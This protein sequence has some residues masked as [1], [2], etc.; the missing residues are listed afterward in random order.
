[1]ALHAIALVKEIPVLVHLYMYQHKRGKDGS[2]CIALHAKTADAL[3]HT[4]RPAR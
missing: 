2:A 1:L 4:C 3:Q